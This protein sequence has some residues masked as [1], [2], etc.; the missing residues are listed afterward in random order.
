VL[1]G[2]H[3]IRDRET[4]F[5]FS[6][7]E[8]YFRAGITAAGY[9]VLWF[10]FEYFL[11][12]TQADGFFS[13]FYFIAFAVLATLLVH[14]LLEMK[15]QDAFLHFCTFGLS[16]GFLRFLIGFG[17]FWESSGLIRYSTAPLPPILPGM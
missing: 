3:F 12:A 1:F 15:T 7:K 4:I 10:G 9:V 2:Y 16:V 13:W 17:W 8:L 11:A 6:G 5:A 14:P